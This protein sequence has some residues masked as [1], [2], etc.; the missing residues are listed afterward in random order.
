M[1]RAH[2]FTEAGVVDP[3]LERAATEREEG[4]SANPAND[5]P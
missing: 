1:L 5:L 3:L 2:G 4:I